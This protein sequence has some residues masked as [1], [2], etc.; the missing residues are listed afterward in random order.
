MKKD[1][2]PSADAAEL[3]CRAEERLRAGRKEAATL[4]EADTQRMMHELQIYQVE[5]E[6]Q[7]EELR[8]QRE[9][10]EESRAQYVDLYEMA[11][12]GYLSLSSKGVILEANLT[13]AGLLG[14]QRGSLV[15]KPLS[16]FVQREDQDTFY[17]F[18]RKLFKNGNRQVCELRMVRKAASPFWVR[19]EAT[20]VPDAQGEA[21]VARVALS[22]VTQRRQAEK[23]LRESEE[24][25]RNLAD[26][27]PE[28]VFEMD[29]KGRLTYVNRNALDVFGYTLQDLGQGLNG[30]G[31]LVPEDRD[32]AI[33]AMQGLYRGERTGNT[34]Y[35]ALKKDGKTFPCMIKSTVIVHEGTPVG[36]RGIIM[37]ITER[38]KAEEALKSAHATLEKQVENRTLELTVANRKLNREV[39]ERQRVENALR[40]SEQRFRTMADFSYDWETWIDSDGNYIYISPSCERITGYS[41]AEFY[42]DKRFLK[43]IVAPQDQ[44]L[45]AKHI[46]ACREGQIPLSAEFRIFTKTGK[47]QWIAHVCQSV[48]GD[49][50]RYLG[51]RA[52]NRDVTAQKEAEAALQKA[53]VQLEKRVEERTKRLREVIEKL[54]KQIAFRKEAEMALKDGE[55][56]L[57]AQKINLEEANTALKILLKRREEDKRELEEKV[58]TNM[59][60][61]IKPYLEK[62]NTGKL[63]DRQ[64]AYVTVLK[65]NVND[66]ISPLARRLSSKW[67]KL[68]PTEI[69]VANLIKQGKTTKEIAELMNL[70]PSTI[71]FHRD[72]IRIKVGIKKTG[73]NLRTYLLS[74]S[75]IST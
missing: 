16:N 57:K 25:F 6:M 69:Q 47:E 49:D 17:R 68:T 35:T 39:K 74:I 60:E 18:R 61:L 65:S 66:I 34:E 11:P 43:K 53:H 15:K 48:Y 63:T 23:D 75:E 52:S 13:A 64:K 44:Q 29:L 67:L 7:N 37:D 24:K 12:V 3:R 50:G 40:E 2:K 9:V 45:I 62:L 4:T 30:L 71:Y 59:N 28:T 72:N 46:E 56:K 73:T 27:L 8:R 20:A 55:I 14:V 10:L 1:K 38:K 19:L 58:L 32:R 21:V 31:M 5:L 26:L 54:N 33:E 42:R 41:P 51:R 70:E 36:L 22:D